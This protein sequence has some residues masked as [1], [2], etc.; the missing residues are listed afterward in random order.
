MDKDV[1]QAHVEKNT[2]TEY[3]NYPTHAERSDSAEYK[4]NRRRLIQLLNLP[5]CVCDMLGLSKL[6]KESLEAHHFV[7]QWALWEHADPSKIQRVFDSGFIDFYGYSKKLHGT[8]VKS[9]DDIRNLVVL[10]ASHHRGNGVGIH[11]TSAPIWFSQLVAKNGI[12]VLQGA[13]K[14]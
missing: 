1:V 9:P 13:I 12:E 2:I 4:G 3:I 6:P 14:K 8:Q 11:E 5:C 7:I 10:C